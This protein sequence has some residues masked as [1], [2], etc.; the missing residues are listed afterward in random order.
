[1]SA[2]FFGDLVD[3][4]AALFRS[5]SRVAQI[6]EH[7]ERRINRS[8]AR[9]VHPTEALLD[10]LDDLVTVP[11]LLVEKAENHE[12]QV[13]LAE[14]PSA[15]ERPAARFAPASPKSAGVKSKVL[16]PHSERPSESSWPAVSFVH[17]LT[18]STLDLSSQ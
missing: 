11:R 9:R 1:M 10:L 4:L 15:D 6:L 8:R 14:H 13:P 2:P 18:P 7:R 3:L 12:L 5:R 16:R 17:R